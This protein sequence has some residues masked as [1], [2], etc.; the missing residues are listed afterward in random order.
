[1]RVELDRVHAQAELRD[2]VHEHGGLLLP[3][4]READAR[5][6]ELV[7]PGD[8]LL[9][10]HGLEVEVRKPGRARQRLNR[11]SST[12]FSVSARSPS[13]SVSSAMTSSGGM[14]PR[15]TSGPKC[16]TNQAC[17][18]LRRRLPDQVVEA[19]R[20]L[21]L[22]HEA[23]P[24]LAGRAVDAG[25]ACLAALGDHLPRTGVEL[26]AHPLHPQVRRDVD[27]GVLRADLGEDDEVAREVGDELELLL[28]RDVE[29]PVRD[30]DVREAVVLEPALE[31]VHLV[32]AVDGLEERPAADDRGR[33][34]AVERDLLLEV[35]GDV[36]RAPAELDD[37]DVLARG[38]EEP[39]DLAQVQPLVDDV[40]QSAL[41]WLALA[42]GHVE[43]RVAV[44]VVHRSPPASCGRAPARRGRGSPRGRRCRR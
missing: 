9:G 28:A 39:L 17:E 12:S 5:P 11:P 7:R 34:R 42:R 6:E 15:L 10:R 1:M 44:I 23:R 24:Q 22:V 3:G 4:A 27:L 21:D 40:R 36:A 30:L 2:H 35:V 41:A 14:F 37:V 13:R 18:A 20:V 19:D 29:R 16:R 32:L 31:V 26:L 25:G 33:E 38:V 8:D 43:E